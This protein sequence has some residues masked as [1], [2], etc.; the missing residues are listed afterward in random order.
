GHDHRRA[1]RPPTARASP[2]RQ[3]SKAAAG[4]QSTYRYVPANRISRPAARTGRPHA[5]GAAGAGR[6]PRRAQ[7]GEAENRGRGAPCEGRGRGAPAAGPSAAAS[8]RTPTGASG[9]VRSRRGGP[10]GARQSDE[11]SASRWASQRV[12]GPAPA[13]VGPATL[14]EQ[15]GRGRCRSPSALRPGR[16][17]CRVVGRPQLGAYAAG[18]WSPSGPAAGVDVIQRNNGRKDECNVRAGADGSARRAPSGNGELALGVAASTVTADPAAELP[19]GPRGI[20]PGRGKST[21]TAMFSRVYSP[22]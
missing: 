1:V 15:A 8:A 2:A 16:N 19:F 21:F 3:G 20:G 13:V 7:S 5:L 10:P 14:G 12:P 22:R 11:S 17:S 6:R 9:P 4:N 18:R